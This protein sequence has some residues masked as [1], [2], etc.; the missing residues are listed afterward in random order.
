MNDNI[1][2]VQYA[3]VDES[4]NPSLNLS[5]TGTSRFYVVTAI[6]VDDHRKDALAGQVHSIRSRF[7]GT[8]E[9]KSSGVKGNFER[10]RGRCPG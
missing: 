2:P 10:R 4:G 8:G 1:Q 6:L 7:F 5:K 3:Y 9:M